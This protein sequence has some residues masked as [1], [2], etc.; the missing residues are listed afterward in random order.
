LLR[1]KALGEC[2]EYRRIQSS[3]LNIQL[4]TYTAG[5]VAIK[6]EGVASDSSSAELSSVTLTPQRAT[7]HTTVSGQLLLQAGAD[8]VIN[9][10]IA[11]LRADVARLIDRTA[12]AALVNDISTN[13]EE[14]SSGSG[15]TARPLTQ[16]MLDDMLRA[17]FSSGAPLISL[18]QAAG[19][20]SRPFRPTESTH[21]T[22]CRRQLTEGPSS[23]RKSC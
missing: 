3:G 8:A 2:L 9:S 5:T 10:L 21:W 23:L 18:L 17:A 7:A 15:T 16:D 13:V 1:K 22:R 20:I 4:P 19:R 6:G 12:F 14:A 11:E